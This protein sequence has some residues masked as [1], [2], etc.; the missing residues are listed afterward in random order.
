MTEA[1]ETRGKT[2]KNDVKRTPS[3]THPGRKE[4]TDPTYCLFFP[5]WWFNRIFSGF[6][7]STMAEHSKTSTTKKQTTLQSFFLHFAILMYFFVCLSCIR[8]KKHGGFLFRNT[9]YSP[10]SF[11][12]ARSLESSPKK[13][14]RTSSKQPPDRSTKQPHPFK[15]GKKTHLPINKAI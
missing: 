10:S 15:K 5:K 12:G 4:P 8:T 11:F 13:N 14:P 7:S 1:G 2:P 9:P 6:W 3:Q